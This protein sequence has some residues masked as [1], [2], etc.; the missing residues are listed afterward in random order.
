MGVGW[1][2]PYKKVIKDIGKV[3]MDVC[4]FELPEKP[5]LEE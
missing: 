3:T 1:N 2:I 5:L 4:L